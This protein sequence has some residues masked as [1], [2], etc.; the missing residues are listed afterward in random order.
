MLNKELINWLD[1][2]ADITVSAGGWSWHEDEDGRVSFAE[3]SDLPYVSVNID[4]A[5]V[6]TD[7]LEYGYHGFGGGD[8]DVDILLDALPRAIRRATERW[9]GAERHG[10]RYTAAEL[11]SDLD[12]YI[13]ARNGWTPNLSYFDSPGDQDELAREAVAALGIPHNEAADEA[14]D[15]E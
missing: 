13:L 7:A 11:A 15:E 6:Y 8:G 9:Y 4:G 5:S 14:A 2:N 10:W 3:A 1:K 12:A